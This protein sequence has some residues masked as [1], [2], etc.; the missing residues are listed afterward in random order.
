MGCGWVMRCYEL[1]STIQINLHFVTHDLFIAFP[2]IP[3]PKGKE[4]TEQTLFFGFRC[5]KVKT[6]PQLQ[7]IQESHVALADLQW[8]N[9]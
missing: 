6:Y 4:Q 1:L 3:T 9:V 8:L 2:S 7:W 5:D